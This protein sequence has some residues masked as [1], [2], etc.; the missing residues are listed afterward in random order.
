MQMAS[1]SV[2][3]GTMVNITML[4]VLE[5]NLE[6]HLA[7]ARRSPARLKCKGCCGPGK[8][9]AAILR[10]A[11]PWESPADARQRSGAAYRVV[12][13][14]QVPC[15]MTVAAGSCRARSIERAMCCLARQHA[16][17]HAPP[18]RQHACMSADIHACSPDGTQQPQIGGCCKGRV[19]AAT[20]G[21][22]HG[23]PVPTSSAR[24]GTLAAFRGPMLLD[25]S[26]EWRGPDGRW[27]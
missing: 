27:H 6:A 14:V 16:C 11:L 13:H 26:G 5:Y 17:R 22:P 2:L 7:S 20:F 3:H 10:R 9:L 23:S 15:T 12:P 8:G 19:L 25:P 1:I 18:R 24:A 21:A 4:H